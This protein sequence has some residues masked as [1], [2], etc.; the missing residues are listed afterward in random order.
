MTYDEEIIELDARLD[1]HFPF[2]LRDYFIRN[3]MEPSRMMA[4]L[5]N[6]RLFKAAMFEEH[7]GNIRYEIDVKPERIII[8]KYELEVRNFDDFDA[9]LIAS[10]NTQNQKRENTLNGYDGDAAFV[11]EWFW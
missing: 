3:Q 1:F 7:P 11:S 9:K 5:H 4:R 6:A 10:R 8:H 2:E